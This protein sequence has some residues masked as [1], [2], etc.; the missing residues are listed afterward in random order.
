MT[1]TQAILAIAIMSAL[2]LLTR[3]LPFLFFAGKKTPDWVGY[4]GGV[5]PCAIMG[6]L[7]V[8]CLKDVSF[9]SLGGFLPA[10]IAGAITVGS[11]VWKKNTLLSILAGT[12]CYMILV[13]FVFAAV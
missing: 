5:L 6:M 9:A 8:F 7:V 2:T 4:L 13:Q 10:L 3:F 11:Y 12:V 1:Q